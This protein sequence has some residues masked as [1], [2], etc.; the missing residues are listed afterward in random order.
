MGEI[1]STLDLVMERTKH[2]TLSE[3]EKKAQQAE[4]FNKVFFGLLQKYRDKI[5]DINRFKKE[6]A[7]L[8]KEYNID[9]DAPMVDE[10]L[11]MIGLERQNSDLI[12][13]L[14]NVFNMDVRIIETLMDNY[15]GEIRD[16]TRQA[17][18][19]A[20]KMFLEKHAISG[21]AVIPNLGKDP[22]LKSRALKIHKD[23]TEKLE[24]AKRQIK[25][26]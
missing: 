18:A 3:D 24:Q 22:E 23:Y 11:S 1:K 12:E 21:D 25:G 7:A 19:A 13:L 14:K 4:R 6:T 20:K 16:L 17:T 10:I 8:K 2:L 5:F 26:N 9:Q 15:T